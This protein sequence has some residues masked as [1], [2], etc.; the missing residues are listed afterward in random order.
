MTLYKM[1][2]GLNESNRL[3]YQDIGPASTADNATWDVVF[4]ELAGTGGVPIVRS[5]YT[6]GAGAVGARTATFYPAVDTGSALVGIEVVSYVEA[7]G[8]LTLTNRTGGALL[9]PTVL[10]DVHRTTT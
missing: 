6:Y 3:M 4:P 2:E 9:L 8:T 10:V 7:T 1:N 5:V